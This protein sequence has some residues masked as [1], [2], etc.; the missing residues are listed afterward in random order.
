VKRGDGGGGCSSHAP[1]AAA[2]AM[3]MM[4]IQVKGGSAPMPTAEDAQRLRAVARRHGADRVLLKSWKPGRAVR[5][6]RLQTSGKWRPVDKLE[7]IF[8]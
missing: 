1:R 6:F 4:L 2:D 3:Q 8:G 5:F 7:T